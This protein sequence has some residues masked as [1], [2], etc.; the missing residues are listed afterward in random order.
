MEKLKCITRSLSIN[1]S[2]YIDFRSS[3]IS[4]FEDEHY[5][6]GDYALA[7]FI[8]NKVFYISDILKPGYPANENQGILEIWSKSGGKIY[9]IQFV[10]NNAFCIDTEVLT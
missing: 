7:I 5:S 9:K 10:S 3:I 6:R 8:D 1:G 4:R 2:Q